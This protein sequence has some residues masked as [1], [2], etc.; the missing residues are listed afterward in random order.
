LRSYQPI[1][2]V[3]GLLAVFCLGIFAKDKPLEF[4]VNSPTDV[5]YYTNM[6]KYYQERV[7]KD[8]EANVRHYGFVEMPDKLSIAIKT[9]I[10]TPDIVQID[11]LFFSVFLPDQI[12]FADLTERV[13]Q[14]GLDRSILPQRLPLFQYKDRIYGLPQSVSAVVLYYRQDLFNEAGIDEDDIDTWPKFIE[15]GKKLNKKSGQALLSMDWSY[16]EIIL[17]QRGYEFFDEKGNLVI[18]SPPVV[19]TM[20]WLSDLSKMRVGLNPD[21]GNIF[22]PTFFSGDVKNNEILC[23]ISAGWYGCDMLSNFTPPDIKGQWRAMPLPAWTD[24]KS[25]KRRTSV[26]AGQGLLIYKK[27][28]QMDRAW[29][30]I[31]FV[32]EDI[33]AN[34]ERFVQR[35]CF[36]AFVPSWADM[37][38]SEPDSVFGGQNFGTVLAELA[39][40]I[41]VSRQVPGRAMVNN[42]LREKYWNRLMIGTSLPAKRGLE[43]IKKE[44]LQGMKRK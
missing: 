29:N 11:E 15:V 33:D 10:N 26:F 38:M 39:Q 14:A 3:S 19:E 23:I 9:G 5:K 16:L 2:K 44:V 24:A 13:K 18:D 32:M 12:P 8:F 6:I 22:D 27:T 35:N 36:P 41:P 28:K 40:H 25:N 21:R 1:I 20:K 43:Q 7:D 37:R 31:R 34:V 42:L 4:W 30:F 17:R